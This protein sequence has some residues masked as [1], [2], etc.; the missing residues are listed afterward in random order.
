MLLSSPLHIHLHLISL[1]VVLLN[2]EGV[3]P[4][5]PFYILVSHYLLRIVFFRLDLNAYWQQIIV[6]DKVVDFSK[7]HCSADLKAFLDVDAQIAAHRAN[8]SVCA[9]I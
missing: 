2:S 3:Y 9:A 7:H 4:F 5:P 8:V 6:I 1:A